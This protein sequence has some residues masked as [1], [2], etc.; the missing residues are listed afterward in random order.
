MKRRP[1]PGQLGLPLPAVAHS[2]APVGIPMS[3]DLFL[4]DFHE[5]GPRIVGAPRPQG[6]APAPGPRLRGWRRAKRLRT[7]QRVARKA[8]RKGEAR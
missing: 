1:M 6:L 3:L 7:L 5:L 4:A 2:T 8:R